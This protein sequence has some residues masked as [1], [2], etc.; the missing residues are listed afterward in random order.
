M[1]DLLKNL[2]TYFVVAHRSSSTK[3]HSR[4]E[5]STDHSTEDH[6]TEDHSTEE[7]NAIRGSQTQTHN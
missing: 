4:E 7:E 1:T 2:L 5:H 3:E 6:S